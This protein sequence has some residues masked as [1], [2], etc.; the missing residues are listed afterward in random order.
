MASSSLEIV[1]LCGSPVSFPRH[2]SPIKLE[3]RKRV[4]RLPN[5]RSWHRLRVSSSALNGG[6]NQSKGQFFFFFFLLL[7]SLKEVIRVDFDYN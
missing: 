2:K 3:C 1:K 4:F 6:D 7:N 5:S